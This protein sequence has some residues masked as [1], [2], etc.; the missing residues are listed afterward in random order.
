MLG[1]LILTIIAVKFFDL[2]KANSKNKWLFAL[3]GIGSYFLVTYTVITVLTSN[4]ASGVDHSTLILFSVPIG[5][6]AS[7]AFYKVL[8]LNWTNQVV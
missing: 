2:A 3:L 5:C 6:L 4:I 7:Y 1:L 8:Q